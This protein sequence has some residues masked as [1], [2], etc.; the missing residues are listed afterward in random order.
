MATVRKGIKKCEVVRSGAKWDDVVKTNMNK[1][2]AT[3][4]GKKSREMALRAM[5]RLEMVSVECS[6]KN[7]CEAVR[8][9]DRW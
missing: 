7:G 1:K 5:K 8:K 6:G 3:G 2:C 9:G 4:R